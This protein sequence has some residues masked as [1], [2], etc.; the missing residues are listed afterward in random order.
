MINMFF[1]I[2]SSECIP[3]TLIN[4]ISETINEKS[5]QCINFHGKR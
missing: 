1:F 3:S 5:L 4:N 2:Q